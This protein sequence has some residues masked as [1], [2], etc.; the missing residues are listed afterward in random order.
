MLGHFLRAGGPPAKPGP[1][2]S[3]RRLGYEVR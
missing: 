1:D 3:A 2:D